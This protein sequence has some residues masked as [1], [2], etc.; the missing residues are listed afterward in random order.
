MIQPERHTQERLLLVLQTREYEIP[1][2]MGFEGTGA[3]G[4][5]LEHL[6]GLPTSNRDVPD[7]AGWEVK[8]SSGNSLVT[9][10]HK[11]P[12]PRGNAIR[13][14][15]TNWGWIGRNGL[16]NFRHTICGESDRFFVVDESN[17]IR[18]RRTNEDD[19]VPHWPHDVLITAFARKMGNLILVHGSKRGR[20]VKYESA[21][22]L[23][24]ARTSRLIRSITNGTICIDFDAYI[25]ANGSIRNHGTK[26]RIKV[27]DLHSIYTGHESVRP[28]RQTQRGES[29]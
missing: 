23:T 1:Q 3:P 4:L 16:Q 10:F 26:F 28:R 9:L 12:Y 18:V 19:L 13:H 29:A 2:G 7:A 22:L 25:Q 24:R 17:A 14:M 11:D 8:F 6:L 27:E 5:Y 21:E 20:V 15:I